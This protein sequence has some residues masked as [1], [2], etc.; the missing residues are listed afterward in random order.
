MCYISLYPVMCAV[1]VFIILYV[2]KI[3]TSDH[4]ELILLVLLR[5]I[6]ALSAVC[7][8]P[9]SDIT[10]AENIVNI[11]YRLTCSWKHSNSRKM[12]QHFVDDNK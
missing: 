7:R 3:R 2:L 1:I 8:A 6:M 10:W 5:L 12:F 9:H 11:R 4:L